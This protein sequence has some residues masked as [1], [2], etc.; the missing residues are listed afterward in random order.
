MGG[1]ERLQKDSE[2]PAG[3]LTCG[4]DQDLRE[5]F[6][7]ALWRSS[8]SVSDSGEFSVL[9]LEDGVESAERAAA[10]MLVECWESSLVPY[11]ILAKLRLVIAYSLLPPGKLQ[12]IQLLCT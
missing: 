6:S 11:M 9:W 12:C 5:R 8:P 7:Q 1:G 10:F 2:Q 3:N 4:A